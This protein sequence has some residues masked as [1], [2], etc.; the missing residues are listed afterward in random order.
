MATLLGT[1]VQSFS[2]QYS[3][4]AINSAITTLIMLRFWWHC[5]KYVKYRFTT[6]IIVSGCVV[7][8]WNILIYWSTLFVFISYIFCPSHLHTWGGQHIRNI[9]QYNAVQY[10]TIGNRDLSAKTYNW[11]NTSMTVSTKTD[12]R[13]RKSR[14]KGRTVTLGCTG[15]PN[16]VQ[17]VGTDV[18]LNS[19]CLMR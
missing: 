19:L 8:D 9:S 18:Y 10:S 3:S 7:L 1:P 11:I 5:Q 12:Y 6:D 2:I 4:S 13:H 14:Q 15:T 17:Y 16:K